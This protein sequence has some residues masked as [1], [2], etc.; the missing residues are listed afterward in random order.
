MYGNTKA[1]TASVL[2]GFTKFL[3]INNIIDFVIPEKIYVSKRVHTPYIFTDEEIDIFFNTAKN[4]YPKCKFKNDI[5]LLCFTLLYCTGIR[6]GECLSI[7]FEDIDFDNKVITLYDTKNNSDRNIVINDYLINKI[8]YIKS[9]YS[10]KYIFN[11]YIFVRPDITRYDNKSIYSVFKKIIYYAKI[12]KDGKTPRVHDFRFT[13]CCKSYNKL[14]KKED[15]NS[16]IPVLSTYVGHKDFKSTE[17]YLK[18][19]AEFY[20][21]IREKTEKYTGNIIRGMSDIDE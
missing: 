6:I 15:S 5:I 13:F 7:K 4:F 19:V 17:Y 2:R 20:P 16:Y 11:D 1:Y 14:L 18:L 8:K 12:E 9:E 21:E 3:F 10:E